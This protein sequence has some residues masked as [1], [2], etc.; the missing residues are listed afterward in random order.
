MIYRFFSKIINLPRRKRRFILVFVDLLIINISSFFA[1]QFNDLR[2]D[3]FSLYLIL[4][5]ISL[6]A[7]ITYIKTNQYR[8][9]IKFINSTFLYYLAL[10][11]LIISLIIYTTSNIFF[12]INFGF[13]NYINFFIATLSLTSLYRFVF[14]DIMKSI[15]N[16]N[17]KNKKLKR[18]VIYGSGEAGSQLFSSIKENSSYKVLCFIDD[19]PIKIN[20]N[21][22][23]LD[24]FSFDY[25]ILKRKQIDQVLF[26]IPSLEINERRRLFRKIRNLSLPILKIPT[27]EEIT[28]NKI[29]IQDMQ[30]LD[31][32]DILRRNIGSSDNTDII[33]TIKGKTV[34]VTGAGG[35]IGSVLTKKILEFNPERIIIVDQSEFYLYKLLDDLNLLNRD[36]IQINSYLG[37]LTDKFFAKRPFDDFK[38]DIVFHAAAYKHVP[39]VEVNKLSGIF[40]NVFTTKILCEIANEKKISRFVLISSDKAV[41]PTNVMGATKRLSELIIQA[42]AEISNDTIFS[43]VRFGNVLGSSGSVIPKFLNQIS[44][45]GPITVTDPRIE[46][47]FMSISEASELL[48]H[49]CAL[50]KGGEVFL[51]DMGKPRK[52]VDLA[53]DLVAAN[54]L[55]VKDSENPDGD[56]EVKFTGLRPGEK[57][58]E[59][60]LI[61]NNSIETT[62]KFIYMA[63]EKHIPFDILSKKL[64]PLIQFIKSND[65]KS[66]ILLLSELVP[67]WQNTSEYSS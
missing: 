51:L 11:I 46:R 4:F 21:L 30:S 36:N 62:N 40:N 47:F 59:E 50:S 20:R 29:L 56:I 10:R 12:F 42:F 14:R 25:L 32:E 39:L 27:I 6:T 26:A 58:Y 5:L 60:L 18:V 55:K 64:Q 19:D 1:F 7:Y 52:I 49:A 2:G 61:D 24:I 28:H 3:R 22:N 66:V 54:G 67:E 65:K 63:H 31:L 9:I 8:S 34:C 44:L 43:M 53:Y 48:L 13:E 41:R 15:I 16:K 35:S 17:K 23:G 45:G 33:N 37:N 38:V 57:L